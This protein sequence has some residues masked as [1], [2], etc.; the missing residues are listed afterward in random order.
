VMKDE[1]IK[2]RD[3]HASDTLCCVGEWKFHYFFVVY[4]KMIK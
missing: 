3:L 4:D 2:L 1:K